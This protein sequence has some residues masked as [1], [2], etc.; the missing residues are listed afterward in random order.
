MSNLRSVWFLV[1]AVSALAGWWL[2]VRP[3][4]S[5]RGAS[6]TVSVLILAV[7]ALMCILA[8]TGQT[9]APSRPVVLGP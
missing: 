9:D 4:A 8:L 5:Y 1:I 6:A 2:A 3:G 7:A